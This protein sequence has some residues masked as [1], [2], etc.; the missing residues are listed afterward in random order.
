MLRPKESK[1][2]DVMGIAKWCGCGNLR[3]LRNTLNRDVLVGRRLDVRNR[4]S[5]DLIGGRGATK[6]VECLRKMFRGLQIDV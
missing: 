5:N 1:R 4:Q 6:R 2:S 3:E